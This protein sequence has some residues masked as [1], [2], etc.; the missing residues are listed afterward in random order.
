MVLFAPALA[1][2]PAATLLRLLKPF[3]RM[4]LPSA[5]PS[6][7][8]AISEGMTINFYNSLLDSARALERKRYAASNVPTIA[9][10]DPRDRMVSYEGIISKMT[11]FGLSKWQVREVKCREHTNH[12][13]YHLIADPTVLGQTGW[14][15]VEKATASFL[16]AAPAKD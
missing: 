2:P 14:A 16:K 9:F 7:N 10:M 6:E 12:A 11:R 3:G 13:R 4:R 5:M 1:F 8:R 15:D